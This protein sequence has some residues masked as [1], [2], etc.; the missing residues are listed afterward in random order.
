MAGREDMSEC[1]NKLLLECISMNVGV[2]VYECQDMFMSDRLKY[3][4]KNLFNNIGILN[5]KNMKISKGFF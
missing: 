1:M 3:W 5:R 4:Q 2:L